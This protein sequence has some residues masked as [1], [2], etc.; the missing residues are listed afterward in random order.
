MCVNE[1]GQRDNVEPILGPVLS[2]D[3]HLY[4]GPLNRCIS[5]WW[6]RLVAAIWLKEHA[7][8]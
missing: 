5:Q 8:K 7:W 3:E 2:I 6:A 4:N 1:R